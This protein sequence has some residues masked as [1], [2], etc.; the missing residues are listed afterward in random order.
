MTSFIMKKGQLI[1]THKM[2]EGER[3]QYIALGDTWRQWISGGQVERKQREGR[4]SAEGG[5]AGDETLKH[6]RFC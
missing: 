3:A 1:L 6:L 4:E 2:R 5:W